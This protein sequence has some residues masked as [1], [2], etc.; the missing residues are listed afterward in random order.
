[1]DVHGLLVLIVSVLLCVACFCL[2][3]RAYKRKHQY[4]GKQKERQRPFIKRKR[5]NL[6]PRTSLLFG[7]LQFTNRPVVVTPGSPPKRQ[8]QLFRTLPRNNTNIQ[9]KLLGNRT[10]P[11]RN[12]LGDIITSINQR[13][14]QKFREP[15]MKKGSPEKRIEPRVLFTAHHSPDQGKEGQ[16]NGCHYEEEDTAEAHILFSKGEE[17][18][19]GNQENQDSHTSGSPKPE[20]KAGTFVSYLSEDVAPEGEKQLSPMSTIVEEKPKTQ[21]VQWKQPKS[22]FRPGMRRA[23]VSEQRPPLWAHGCNSSKLVE[24]AFSIECCKK[25]VADEAAHKLEAK[26]IINNEKL[27][28]SVDSVEK[29][30][31]SSYSSSDNGSNKS[32]SNPLGNICSDSLDD[33]LARRPRTRSHRKKAVKSSDEEPNVCTHKVP[34]TNDIVA[35]ASKTEVYCAQCGITLSKPQCFYSL[36]SLCTDGEICETDSDDVNRHPV[37]DIDMEPPLVEN[38]SHHDTGYTSSENFEDESNLSKELDSVW[39]NDKRETDSYDG[40]Y[41]SDSEVVDVKPVAMSDDMALKPLASV[42]E[43]I[44]IKDYALREWKSDTPTSLAMKKGYDSISALTGCGHLRQIRGD[45]YCAI[46][47]VLF[48]ALAGRL[49]ILRLFGAKENPKLEKIPSKLSSSGAASLD[50]WSFANR[51]PVPQNEV[52]PTLENYLTFFSDQI[53]KICDSPSQPE[54]IDST[55][56]LLNNETEEFKILEA[57]KLLMFDVAVQLHRRMT[58]GEDVP[59]FAMLLFARDSSDS[60][61]RL[62]TNHLNRTGDTGGL[63]QVEMCLLGYTL[64]LVIQVIRPSQ[65]NKEDFIAY[66]PSLDDVPKYTPTVTLVAEDDRHYNIVM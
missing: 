49:P 65:V 64:G 66:Y 62:L 16:S 48:Q 26:E 61:R 29:T 56:S 22:L 44:A 24:K 57:T 18:S 25:S 3:V 21:R 32:D 51:L 33:V 50:Q 52:I 58:S 38:Q 41:E 9:D 1:M 43:P 45:N 36:G 39:L 47:A 19:S 46:R 2:L 34:D 30:M 53:H 37:G 15:I 59:I 13:P 28:T 63:E 42:G 35:N 5:D 8:Q 54:R 11:E 12:F 14:S 27:N 40:D 7:N 10:W 4:R 6:S 17:E 31:R 55:L 20:L 60:P 23:Q